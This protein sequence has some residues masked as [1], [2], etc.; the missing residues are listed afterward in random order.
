MLKYLYLGRRLVFA[1]VSWVFALIILFFLP[2]LMPVGPESLLADRFR[3]PQE[4]VSLMRKEF[5][6]DLPMT[7]QFLRFLQNV[8]FKFPPDFGYSYVHF[9]IKV[10]D[11]IMSHLPWTIY[12]MTLSI[13]VTFIIGTT[14]GIYAAWKRSTVATRVLSVIALLGLSSPIFWVGYILIILFAFIFPIL[15]PAGAYSVRLTPAFNIEFTLSLLKHSVLPILTIVITQFPFYFLLT[16]DNMLLVFSEDYVITAMAKGIKESSLVFKHVARNALLP[17]VTLLG[18]QI[19]LML[20]G[21]IMV[22]AV[23]S[24]PGVGKLIVDAI[25]GVD[26]PVVAGFFYLIITVGIGASILTDFI[27]VL[28]DPRVRYQ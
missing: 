25:L 1:F 5:G 12:L 16:R 20:G 9:P 23:F 2:R 27:Y 17:A 6:L 21:Q 14:A 10:K 4:A 19:G 18:T 3:L 7:Q 22:E 24:Y 8:V 15:P 13:L 11:L 28:L 26:Y